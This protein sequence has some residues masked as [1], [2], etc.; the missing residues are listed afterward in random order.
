MGLVQ[1]AYANGSST[2]YI[3]DKLKVPVVCVPTGV[4]HLH[5]AAH[6]FDIGVYFEANGHGTVL[7][8]NRVAQILA[9][10]A[11]S[12]TDPSVKSACN[13]LDCL[14]RMINPAVGDA[15][16]D[17]LAVEAILADKHW[18]LEDW[19]NCYFDL[20]SRQLKVKVQDRTAITTEDAE[21]KCVTPDGLQAKIEN[22]Y[23]KVNSGRSFV[24]PSGTEDVVRVYAEA[25]TQETADW[26]AYDVAMATY[27]MAGGV[28]PE[29]T[30]PASSRPVE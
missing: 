29:P 30:K 13:K 14:R 17:L 2:S 4:K 10:R 9:D 3:C 23:E 5:K 22:I 26:L 24:R 7:F 6:S 28:A 21:R 27:K 19:N 16:S 12:T 11:S 18:S 1:T 25:T 20:P 15:F 8:S